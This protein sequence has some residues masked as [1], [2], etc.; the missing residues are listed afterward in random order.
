MTGKINEKVLLLVLAAIQF[1]V[2]VD[3]LI[4]MPLGP[5][6]MRVFQISAQDFSI[7]VASYAL[8]AGISGFLSGFFLDKYDRKSALLLLFSGFTLGTFFCA[9]APTYN[10]LV[11]SR[12][13]AGAFGGLVGALI[14]AI[15]GDVIPYERRGAAMGIVMSSF[16]AASILGVPLGLFLA[17][18]FNWHVP[19][20]IL[21]GICAGTLLPIS[22]VLPSMKAHMEHA[23]GTH[24]ARKILNV[25][26]HRDHQMA[27]ILMALITFGG[28]TIFPYLSNYMVGNVGMT[29]AELPLIYL[30]GGSCTIFSLNL[31]GKWSDKIGKLKAFR[32]M[33]AIAILPILL[34]TNLP[35]VPLVAAIATSTFFMICISGRMVPGMALI[36]GSIEARYRGGFMS[37]NSSIQQLSSGI[38]AYVSGQVIGQAANGEMTNFPLVG[39]FSVLCMLLSIYCAGFL[40]IVRNE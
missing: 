32:I 26:M 8:A 14:L 33:C 25:F 31:I 11:L 30:A 28:F 27:F 37:I 1:T 21:A 16:S 3:F 19:F 39:V 38:A 22:R 15:I 18:H 24:P 6:Y 40:K 2:V 17:T 20:F 12:I 23:E 7:I 13:V 36:T 4:I 9:L 5:Q 34:L 29:E 35:R 10:L